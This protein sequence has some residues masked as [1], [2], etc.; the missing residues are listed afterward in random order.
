[1]D[2]VIAIIERATRLVEEGATLYET[3]KPAINSLTGK[4]PVE[5]QQAKDRLERS[6]AR[7]AEAGANL[8]DAIA[9]QLNK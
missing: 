6:L 1:M 8:N 4:R 5:L 9:A 7:A 2:E 3:A